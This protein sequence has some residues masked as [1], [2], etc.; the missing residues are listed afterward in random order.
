MEHAI[1][2]RGDVFRHEVAG[3]GDPLERDPAMVLRDVR[4]E[5]VSLASARADYGV[6]FAGNPLAVDDAPTRALREQLRR[7]RNWPHTP[8][9]SWEPPDLAVAAERYDPRTSWPLISPALLAA[10]WMLMYH[11]PLSS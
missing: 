1:K 9:I 7:T 5:L 2:H 6:V 10:V 3:W 11:L 8:D 4:N